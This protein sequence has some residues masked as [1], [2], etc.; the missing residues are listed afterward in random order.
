MPNNKFVAL[1]RDVEKHIDLVYDK[2][3]DLDNRLLAIESTLSLRG[4]K[5]VILVKNEKPKTKE[6]ALVEEKDGETF[7]YNN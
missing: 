1:I 5:K 2:L 4:P 6:K 3:C 7:V